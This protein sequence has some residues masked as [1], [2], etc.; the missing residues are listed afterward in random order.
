[1]EQGP[2][3]DLGKYKGYDLSMYNRTVFCASTGNIF[4]NVGLNNFHEILTKEKAMTVYIGII[5]AIKKNHISEE[6]GLTF[7]LKLIEATKNIIGTNEN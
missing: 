2:F 5:R 7:L 1:M 4:W 6:L 3:Y